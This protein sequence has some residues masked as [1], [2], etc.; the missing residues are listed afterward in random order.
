MCEYAATDG[1]LEILKWA[2]AKGCPWDI[3][4][5]IRTGDEGHSEVF[6]W[7]HANGCP[8]EE[9][10]LTLVKNRGYIEDD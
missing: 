8:C 10:L 9:S 6:R 2:R 7:A 1:Y 5:C 4:T 3:K